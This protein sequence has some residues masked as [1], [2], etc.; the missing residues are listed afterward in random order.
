[1]TEKF[2]YTCR[3]TKST[4]CFYKE[5]RQLDG[6]TTSCKDCRKKYLQQY[7]DKHRSKL[8]EQ[9]NQ[10]RQKYKR[11]RMLMILAYL[12]EHGCIDCGEDDPV[13]LDFD[14]VS[15]EK[16]H[17]ISEMVHGAFSKENILKEIEKCVV[18]CSNCHRRKTAKE[19]NWYSYIDFETMTIKD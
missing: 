15:G 19:A 1:M 11:E 12:K 8:N 16:S 9:G 6:L 4:D 10:W 7:R 3:Q 17:N 18:R 14:H 5:K 2:C 13:V